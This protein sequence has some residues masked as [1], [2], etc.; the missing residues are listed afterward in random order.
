VRGAGRGRSLAFVVAAVGAA[1]AAA[2]ACADLGGLSSGAGGDDGGDAGGGDG[3]PAGDGASSDAPGS[4]GQAGSKSYLAVFGGS[5]ANAAYSSESYL[6]EVN[7]DGSLG[8]WTSI[9]GL[10]V[11]RMRG[12]TVIA[13]NNVF[14]VGG[15]IV[16]D[17]T[18]RPV[19]API[20]DASVGPWADLAVA[21]YPAGLFRNGA[22]VYQGAIFLVGGFES[23]TVHAEVWRVPVS[24]AGDL[25][26][27]AQ[28]T[29]LPSARASAVVG[30]AQNH[31]YV[32]S[33]EGGG[34]TGSEGLVG[35]IA[36][37]GSITWNTLP[38]LPFA[39]SSAAGLV[40]ASTI[41][42]NGGFSSAAY[43]EGARASI[44]ASGGVSSWL[45]LPKTNV[46]RAAHLMLAA[47]GHLY[48][49]GGLDG[50]SVQIASVEVSDIAADGSLSPWRTTT[51]LPTAISYPFGTVLGP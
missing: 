8:P 39:T 38:A 16:N 1:C 26:T 14:L 51:P 21:P 50:N 28:T 19:G 3:A 13:S 25:G 23:S 34:A 36:A 5:P 31:L 45:P 48:V 2:L 46:G 4:D 37:D 6:A 49:I 27:W 18:S 43:T 10:P 24:A 11:G 15:D 44:A 42:V 29:S 22:V 47:R 17:I 41:Y 35:D 7:D 33:G 12:G 40:T 20:K 30:L 9:P 32:I